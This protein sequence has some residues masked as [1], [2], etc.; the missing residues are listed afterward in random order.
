MHLCD[1]GIVAETAAAAAIPCPDRS[2]PKAVGIQ[3]IRTDSWIEYDQVVMKVC[4]SLCLGRRIHAVK[5][6]MGCFLGINA[7]AHCARDRRARN[8]DTVQATVGRYILVQILRF[9]KA[10]SIDSRMTIRT[11]K[12][13]RVRCGIPN[14]C[15]GDNLG[16]IVGGA[17]TIGAGT[18]IGPIVPTGVGIVGGTEAHE[19]CGVQGA[20]IVVDPREIAIMAGRTGVTLTGYVFVVLVGL[21]RVGSVISIRSAGSR[22][23]VAIGATKQEAVRM[24]MAGGAHLAGIVGVVTGRAVL[25]EAG[26][27]VTG[28]AD[29][30]VN[31]IAVS[32]GM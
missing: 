2:C 4:V 3:R 22:R 14:R 30:V 23:I 18:G 20:I 25:V 1:A 7:V 9:G 8:V 6:D 11:G 24:G 19:T 31:R 10:L 5:I 13:A 28:F 16:A 26:R 12:A 17:V 21:K 32:E 15:V 27:R 29:A